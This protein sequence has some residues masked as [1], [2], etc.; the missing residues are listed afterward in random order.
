MP[1]IWLVGEGD[2]LEAATLSA[3]LPADAHCVRRFNSPGEALR[4]SAEPA[5]FVIVVQRRPAEF[6]R[7]DCEA[8]LGAAP[9]ARFVVGLG[10]WCASHHRSERLWPE[11][12]T[13]PLCEVP[14]RF[15]REVAAFTAG[16]PPLPLTAGRDEAILAGHQPPGPLAD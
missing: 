2:V 1:V 12:V 5:D 14:A 7:R 8:L 9:L 11:T 3:M 15:A 4:A 6:S 13:V 10:P 16:R